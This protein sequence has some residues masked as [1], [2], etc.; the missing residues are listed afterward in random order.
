MSSRDLF[1]IALRVVGVVQLLSSVRY[2][3]MLFP[4]LAEPRSVLPAVVYCAAAILLSFVFLWKA[5]AIA[6]FLLKRDGAIDVAWLLR[7]P[8][9]VLCGYAKLLALMLMANVLPGWFLWLPSESSSR[10]SATYL[11]DAVDR[12]FA[13][14]AVAGHLL[15]GR[16]VV[17]AL[18]VYLLLGAPG[19]V[20]LAC[21]NM[22]RDVEMPSQSSDGAV[23]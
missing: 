14:L 11:G 6:G 13:W 16:L 8:D 4:P 17:I 1:A 23:S 19:L 22:P 21:R 7:R 12:F 18:F 10:S 5:D 15:L 9:V 20:K 3:L 2:P